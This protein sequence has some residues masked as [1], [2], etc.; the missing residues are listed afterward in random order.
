MI[1]MWIIWIE[2]TPTTLALNVALKH[3]GLVDAF[4]FVLFC[5]LKKIF[6]FIF[7]FYQDLLIGQTSQY[8]VNRVVLAPKK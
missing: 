7:Q 4:I 2:S 8:S 6:K 1:S 3:I 5:F